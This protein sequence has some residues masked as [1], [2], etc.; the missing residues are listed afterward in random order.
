MVR[1]RVVIAWSLQALVTVSTSQCALLSHGLD[2]AKDCFGFD[3]KR[4]ELWNGFLPVA[5]DLEVPMSI[6]VT[7]CCIEIRVTAT[8]PP[9]YI[10]SYLFHAATI[11]APFNYS[12]ALDLMSDT[13]DLK[14]VGVPDYGDYVLQVH[15]LFELRHGWAPQGAVREVMDRVFEIPL[16]LNRSAST[17]LHCDGKFW[18]NGEWCPICGGRAEALLADAA[19]GFGHTA[20][21]DHSV[22]SDRSD[23]YE[24]FSRVGRILLVG[25]SRMRLVFY[26]L[27]ELLG[28]AHLV[29]NMWHKVNYDLEAG[30]RIFFLWD[31]C[32]FDASVWI[33]RFEQD[34]PQWC[35]ASQPWQPA[36]I[37]MLSRG[38]CYTFFNP[39]GDRQELRSELGEEHR[40]LEFLTARCRAPHRL[41]FLLE[42]AIHSELSKHDEFKGRSSF[43]GA[44]LA[45]VNQE[46]LALYR[47]YGLPALDLFDPTA[48]FFPNE[49][50][51]PYAHYYRHVAD[52]GAGYT[53]ESEM[54]SAASRASALLVLDFLR[55]I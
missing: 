17:C 37:L 16:A 51:E 35:S 10:K 23:A 14:T 21:F 8:Q 9:V 24:N 53:V 11:S 26:E 54:G 43:N 40:R 39:W 36:D 28:F 25:T 30:G 18:W 5:D 7:D 19:L 12:K 48:S 41:V 45:L 22:N 50:A 46:M 55:T 31:K 52:R 47:A 44:R 6:V 27:V 1:L 2:G 13:D 32:D 34:Y 49:G 15:G 29:D 42:A 3:V 33:Q 20:H 38:M 4:T